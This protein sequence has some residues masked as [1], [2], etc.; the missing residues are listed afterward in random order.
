ML[1]DGR[2]VSCDWEVIKHTARQFPPREHL[3]LWT[4]SADRAFVDL[5]GDDIPH[6]M[7]ISVGNGPLTAFHFGKVHIRSISA[8]SDVEVSALMEEHEEEPTTRGRLRSVSAFVDG[9]AKETRALGLDRP[10][11]TGATTAHTI[12]R[13]RFNPSGK[14]RRPQDENSAEDIDF[15]RC[16]LYGG[17]TAAY[18]KG[19]IYAKG[20]KPESLI[21]TLD[22]PAYELPEGFRLWRLDA[23]SAYPAQMRR[24]LP[25]GWRFVSEKFDL[26]HKHGIAEVDLQLNTSGPCVVPLRLV[27][28]G[29]VSTQWPRGPAVLQGV[30]SY[31]TIREA[32][33]YGAKVLHV[34]SAKTYKTSQ[35]PLRCFVEAVW[36]HQKG[37]GS[38]SVRKA[39]KGYSRRLNGRFAVSR[40]QSHL[41]SLREYFDWLEKEPDAPMP[42]RV[43]GKHCLV[44]QC[45]PEYPAYSQVMWSISTID[46]ATVT[47]TRLEHALESA[48][49]RVLYVDT[50]SVLFSAR[51]CADGTPDVPDEVRAVLGDGLGDWRVDW[52][53]NPHDAGG[54]WACILGSKYY[55]LSGEHGA[56]FAGV[57]RAI[58]AELLHNGH[59]KYEQPATIFSGARTVNYNL[60]GGRLEEQ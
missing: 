52:G 6:G 15:I 53:P 59:A 16:G 38:E 13:E 49:L 44:R 27:G 12:W 20:Y 28:E 29:G 46:R 4:D 17:K 56:H 54:L 2:F 47:L 50:D 51:E 35:Y 24:D 42:A 3:T 26:T 39:V 31:F 10:R 37:I 11:G 25:Y 18:V 43:I 48:G 22:A 7:K 41:V 45:M 32:L 34:H 14:W 60:R 19:I 23:R 21:K 5:I 57:P 58:Q 33:R 40:W 30:W 36:D 9:V 8:F 55:A 1:L